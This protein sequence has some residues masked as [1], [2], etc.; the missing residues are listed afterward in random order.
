MKSLQP[1]PHQNSGACHRSIR[2]HGG[3]SLSLNISGD[4]RQVVTSIFVRT[5][6][7]TLQGLQCSRL[8]V[9]RRIGT[10]IPNENSRSADT[11]T[12]GRGIT[13]AISRAL[14]FQP[15]SAS[16]AH[17]GEPDG[18]STLIRRDSPGKSET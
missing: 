8:A 4:A 17:R 5:E 1:V 15:R 11:E 9:D 6:R 10:P 14:A 18:H 2:R 16:L 13:T 12:Q 3:I 7:K